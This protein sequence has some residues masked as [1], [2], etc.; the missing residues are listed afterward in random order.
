MFLKDTETETNIATE[1]ERIFGRIA[2]TL[3]NPNDTRA[4]PPGIP[5]IEELNE[6][7]VYFDFKPDDWFA[8]AFALLLVRP[9]DVLAE[10]IATLPLNLFATTTDTW[11][12]GY[13]LAHITNLDT[14]NRLSTHP[15]RAVRSG[16]AANPNTPDELRVMLALAGDTVF[17]SDPRVQT[18]TPTTCRN[19]AIIDEARA[20]HIRAKH[21]SK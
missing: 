10:H 13:V 3:R 14:L 11:R 2:W 17:A 5:T 18:L 15:T 8:I 20:K 6:L 4:I 16:V 19:C 12:Y 9:D 21:T 7:T 1:R